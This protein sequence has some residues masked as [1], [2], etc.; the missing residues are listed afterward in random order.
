M[1]A[2]WIVGLVDACWVV[3]WLL[4]GRFLV[5]CTVGCLGKKCFCRFFYFFKL[6]F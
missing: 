2:F 3:G 4:G 1:D 6:C 5:S